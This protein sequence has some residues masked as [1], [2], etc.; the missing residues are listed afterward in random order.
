MRSANLALI[1]STLLCPLFTPAAVA[2]PAA[3][4]HAFAQPAADEPV[5]LVA[6]VPAPPS[7]PA[8]ADAPPSAAE[9]IA[10]LERSIESDEKRL[11][12]IKSVLTNP[13]GEYARAEAS[14]KEIDAQRTALRRQLEQ[15]QDTGSAENWARLKEEAAAVDKKWEL[16]K[17]RFDLVISGRKSLQET[18]VTLERKLVSD[19]E[20]L[21][22]L[23]G[24]AHPPAPIEAT[25]S[26]PAPAANP[27][28]VPPA[29][30]AAPAPS[31]PTSASLASAALDPTKLSA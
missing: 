5:H 7:T 19:R 23:H 25:A 8:E 22:K 9:R 13:D 21:Q 1:F 2:Q 24:G 14:F 4:Q 11:R 3:A 29:S 15:S 10:R 31:E 30:A 17:E 27:L 26:A 28:P 20:T 16:A 18:V 6:A 12:T